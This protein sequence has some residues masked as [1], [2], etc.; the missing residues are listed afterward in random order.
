M[1]QLPPRED[2]LRTVTDSTHR[3]MLATCLNELIF[4]SARDVGDVIVD[5]SVEQLAAFFEII[6]E[7][8][9]E[10]SRKAEEEFYRRF[11][12]KEEKQNIGNFF[13]VLRTLLASRAQIR[14]VLVDISN[15]VD[16]RVLL[17]EYLGREE[18][19]TGNDR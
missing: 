5:F 14:H 1:L 2:A 3:E 15:P 13:E 8:N 19:L 16:L 9:F 17:E 4:G 12:V 18:R 11:V 6:D 10:D 7:N